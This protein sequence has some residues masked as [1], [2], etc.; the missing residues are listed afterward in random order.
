MT[1]LFAAAK[2][3]CLDAG[4]KLASASRPAGVSRQVGDTRSLRRGYVLPHDIA[5][6]LET[7][8]AG[9]KNREAA[10]ALA[11]FLARFWSSRARL[12][13]PFPI[14]R[15]ALADREDL[16]LTEAKIRGALRVLEEIGYLNRDLPPAGS[17]HKM[18]SRRRQDSSAT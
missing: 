1:T 18:T 12:A 8:L 7:A 6:R 5:Q 14:D 11:L 9:Y 13:R 15:R 2:N 3:G 4:A 16:G 17:V 10:H